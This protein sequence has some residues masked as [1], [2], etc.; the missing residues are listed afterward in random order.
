VSPSAVPDPTPVEVNQVLLFVMQQID[1]VP[2]LEALMLLWQSRP[3]E[4]TAAELAKRLYI[5]PEQAEVIFA[6]LA[7]KSLVVHV[8][9]RP[10]SYRY[11]QGSAEQ[12]ELMARTEAVYRKQIVRISSLIHSKPSSAVRDFARAFRFTKE[13]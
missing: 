11:E 4:W 10:R 6:D 3:A 12:D 9:D 1:S 7:R 13:K 8:P 2:E 5:V